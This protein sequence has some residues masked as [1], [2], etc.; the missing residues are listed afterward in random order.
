MENNHI[1]ASLAKVIARAWV[2]MDFKK[3]LKENPRDTLNEMGIILSPDVK[4]NVVEDSDEQWYLYLPPPPKESEEGVLSIL[5]MSSGGSS[6]SGQCC[7]C[8]Q[9]C[10]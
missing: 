7:K 10:A 1:Q 9:P 2:D 5:P 3:R 6:S 8:L 4:M